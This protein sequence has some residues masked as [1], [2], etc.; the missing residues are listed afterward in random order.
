MTEVA[1]P[2][3]RI[4]AS[5]LHCSCFRRGRSTC[6]TS[7]RAI[8]VNLSMRTY[9]RWIEQDQNKT[10]QN[11]EGTSLEAAWE[12]E[13]SQWS[14]SSRVAHKSENNRQSASEIVLRDRPHISTKHA[15]SSH[16]AVQDSPSTLLSHQ[17]SSIHHSS[18]L[19]CHPQQ[20]SATNLQNRS[21]NVRSCPH[22]SCHVIRCSICSV[23][24][25]VCLQRQQLHP[26][27]Q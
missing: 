12:A 22:A 25:Q 17:E 24:N 3:H 4:P 1:R 21:G 15:G 18:S 2:T 20:R 27:L 7:Q 19:Q 5:S 16:Q 8:P 13:A 10:S 6:G 26:A 14:T 9:S 23:R 11:C